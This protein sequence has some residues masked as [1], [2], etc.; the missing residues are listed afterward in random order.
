VT[1]EP[2]LQ[3]KLFAPRV[4]RELVHRPRLTE[5][6][7]DQLGGGAWPSLL[8]VSAPAG[9]GKSTL[10]AQ[11]LLGGSGP[12][13]APVAWL[14]LDSGDSDPTT[15]WAYVLAALR[16]ALPTVGGSAQVLLESPGSTPITTV[17]TTL[18]NDLAAAADDEVVLVLDDYHV[19]STPEVH[20]AMTFLVEHLPPQLH[21]V[22]ATRSDPP[23][24][25]ARLRARGQLAEIR[26]AD[27]RFN[28]EETAAYFD[29]MG[30]RLSAVDVATLDSRT[31]GWVAALQLAA[32][33]LRGRDDAAGF[34][35]GFAGDD[36]H[37]VD[38]LVEEVVHRQPDDVRDFLLRTSVLT[39]LSGPLT[40]AVT[41]RRDGRAMLETLDRGNLFLVRLDEQRRWY[42]YHHLFADML[43]A[44][45]LDEQPGEVPE[46]HRRA[47][48][49]HEQDGDTTAAIDHALAAGDAERAAGLVEL[50][51]RPMGK[52]RREAQLRRWM[53]ALPDEVFAARPVL[54]N[55]YV[56]A[57]MS[58]GEVRG[59]EPRLQIAEQWVEAVRACATGTL[60]EGLLVADL[61]DLE[62]LPGWVRIHRAGLSLMVGD[63]TATIEHG[64]GAIDELG[65]DDNLGHAA[66]TALMGIAA[67]RQGDLESA[68]TA[69]ATSMRRFEAEGWVADLLGCAITLADLQW[70]RG[71]LRDAERTYRDALDLAA[72]QPGGP[73]RGAPDMHVGLGEIAIE[74]NDLTTAGEELRTSHEL[75]DHLGMPRHPHR[76]RIAEAHLREAEGDLPAALALL[77]EAE[78]VYDGDFSPDVRP[79]TAMRARIWV[80]LGHPE[81]T[82]AWAAQRGLAVADE[83]D[84]LREYEHVTLARA[85]LAAGDPAAAAFLERLLGAAGAGGRQG[86]ALEILVLLAV[87]R[88]RQ[89]D[90]GAAMAALSRALELGEPEGY[91]RTFTDEGLAMTSLLTA[92]AKRGIAPAYAARLLAPT[93]PASLEPARHDPLVDPLSDRE[94]EVLRLLATE[95]S[96]PEIA[97]H[98]VVS[99]NTV[100]THTKNIYTKLA[101]GS[102][103]EAVRR[104]E[105]LGLLGHGRG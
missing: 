63:V 44:Q 26:A 58:T 49:W 34:I 97:R 69:Y 23:L 64:R 92:A 81:Q 46:L 100:R 1:S 72:R 85:L 54:A 103:R 67:W 76:W 19:I 55:G 35:Q 15:F 6:L 10:L 93:D 13:R 38:Y 31:E 77:D 68:A 56:G 18:L 104:A 40:D 79:V 84:Y 17:L 32:L 39:R 24:P 60:P 4:T 94:L 11:A 101:V 51:I 12:G 21:L 75:G 90:I 27:L 48:A 96:G 20:E 28:E 78:R 47:S 57:L 37:V 22:L 42:R 61:A 30:L 87:A 91:V 99:L 5:L 70:A 33:S 74:R 25:L 36:R 14:S 62:R 41:G 3:T 8:L 102:R 82:I 29:G 66:A 65:R 71:R 98:L 50:S 86:T 7:G 88:Q 73:L 53:E 95:L 105:A 83:P 45:L 2:L 52:D 80:K 9:F 89:G 59:V 43:Q 16:T